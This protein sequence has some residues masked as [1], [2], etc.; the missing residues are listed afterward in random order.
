MFGG[1]KYHECF[2]QGEKNNMLLKELLKGV[3]SV[4]KIDLKLAKSLIE[5][6]P[7]ETMRKI[8]TAPINPTMYY[9]RKE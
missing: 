1:E 4:D 5:N 6:G 2:I 3:D 7:H 9:M 8:P